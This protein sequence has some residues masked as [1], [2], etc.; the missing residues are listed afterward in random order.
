MRY[1]G[2]KTKL[3]EFIENVIDKHKIKGNSFA[4]LFAGTGSVG[5]FFKGRYQIISNDFMYYSFVL[6]KA[7]LSFNTPPKFDGFSEKYSTNIFNWLNSKIFKPNK[8]FFMYNNYSPIGDRMFF[9]KEN[10]LKI[11]GIRI[12][13]EDLY[14]NKILSQNEYYYILA[15]LLKSVTKVSNT[16]GTYEAFFKFWESRA[17]KDFQIEPLDLYE[18]KTTREHV[19]YNEETNKIVRQIEGDIAY[20]DPPYSVTQYA[21]AYHVLE[22]I[23]RYDFPIIR[24]VGG[25]RDKGKNVSLYSRKQ[26]AKNQFEDLFRQI[27]FNHILLSYSNQS[28]VELDELVLLA[29]KFAVNNK[30]HVEELNYKE[31]KN[32]RSSN[33]GNGKKLKEVIIYFI[34]DLKHNKSPLNYSGSKNTVLNE[35][36]KEL[37]KKVDVFVDAMGGAFNV[38][39]NIVANNK[40]IYNEN[41]PYIYNLINWI[42][43]N[44]RKYLITKIEKN[45]KSFKLKK[46][47]K[48]EYIK[49]RD[50]YNKKDSS[51]LNLYTLHMYGFQNMIRF[52]SSK[53]YNTPNGVAGYSTDIKKR[54]LSF[55]PKTKKVDLT[56]LC[57]SDLEYNTFEKDT[58]FYFD[59]PYFITSAAYNDGKRGMKGWNADSEIELLSI[60][61]KIDKLGLKFILSN[62]ISHKGKTNHILNEWIDE[63]KYKVVPIGKSGWRYSKNE[64]LIK[65]FND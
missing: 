5:D 60:L 64:V 30:V 13:T 62:V 19:V 2:N 53:K 47:S 18:C 21:S 12:T 41:N 46:G 22:T 6:N 4:D 65:N 45:I 63:H 56:N 49:L 59:P 25:K 10:A 36:I 27:K 24:G 17:K 43:N 44:D 15:S 54:M 29:K 33:K 8:H 55:I 23:A 16:S 40:V 61:T 34:K 31:Y 3:L 14:K 20:L 57:Y 42:I 48:D 52:N 50:Y 1:L 35:I 28:I 26:L 38:G 9:T 7:K 32:H 11:D 39:A 37:P 51:S 58:L